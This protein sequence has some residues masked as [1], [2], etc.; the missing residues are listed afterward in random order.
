MSCGISTNCVKFSSVAVSSPVLFIS[1]HASYQIIS[2]ND[3]KFSSVA[4]ST[5]FEE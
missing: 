2:A 3:V 5:D 1:L 4:V